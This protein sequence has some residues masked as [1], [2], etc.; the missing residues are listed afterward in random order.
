MR[1]KASQAKVNLWGLKTWKDLGAAFSRKNREE[2]LMGYFFILPA[3]ALFLVFGVYPFYRTITISFTDWDGISNAYNQIGFQNYLTMFSDQLWWRSL[4]NGLFFSWTAIVFMNG[5]ALLLA[6]AV[7]RKIKGQTIYRSLFYI[8]TIL[9]G[10]VVAIIW[11]WLYQPIGGPLNQ[12]LGSIG[13]ASLQTA[14][15]ASSKTVLWAISI[16]SMWASIGSPFLLF[17]AGLQSVPIELYEAARIDG[18]N[19][20][21]LFRYITVPF[22]VPVTAIITVLT[23]LGAMQ[24]FNIVLTM[25]SGG[26]G[27]ASEVPILHIYREG[28]K[29]YD[30]GYASALS[31]TFG[32]LLFGISIF[33]L[34]LSRK[35]GIRAA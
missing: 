14:W 34:W 9:S 12:I 13:L 18:G 20:W 17:L 2:T 29:L 16:A 8:P 21:Q 6:L 4:V 3:V 35:I 22:L 26:P 19:D 11:K 23:F 31:M 30:F 32:I 25:T 10:V 15:L 7:D 33:Q 1:M 28:F 24:I 5:I 27:F